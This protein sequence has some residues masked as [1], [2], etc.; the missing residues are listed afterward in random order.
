MCK[1]VEIIHHDDFDGISAAG[2]MAVFLK[3]YYQEV[4]EIN[5]QAIDYHQLD[6]F[7]ARDLVHETAVVDFPLHPQATWWFDHHSTSFLNEKSRESYR[8]GSHMCWDPKAYSCPQILL[9]TIQQ[10]FPKIYSEKMT[11]FQQITEKANMIDSALYPSVEHIY[12]LSDPYTTFNHMLS[13]RKDTA[14]RT[15]FL[16]ALENDN[17]ASWFNTEDFLT[18]KETLLENL[19]YQKEYVQN[20]IKVVNG[21]AEID[22]LENKL[23]VDRFLHYI[24]YPDVAYTITLSLKNGYHLGVGRNPWKKSDS[25]DIGQ[26]LK[27]YG[28]G[29]RQNVGALICSSEQKLRELA[30]T[31]QRKLLE[32]LASDNSTRTSSVA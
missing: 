18:R 24:I 3:E 21:I 29:G 8:E 1:K 17:L 11:G 30:A 5:Y 19:T 20:H 32:Q 26:F 7:F 14:I 2:I 10:H 9:S 13:N 16:D 28:G 12:D 27:E 31:I 23:G 25:L 22:F 4:L 15:Q 6:E